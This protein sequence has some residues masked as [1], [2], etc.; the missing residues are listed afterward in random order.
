MRS[1]NPE[2]VR[3]AQEDDLFDRP[4]VEAGRPVKLTG[5][6]RPFGLTIKFTECVPKDSDK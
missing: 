5:T 6:N 2:G 1:P 3:R 4:E